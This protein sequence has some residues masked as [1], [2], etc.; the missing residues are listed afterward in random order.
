M[1]NP[2]ASLVTYKK[3][4]NPKAL[5]IVFG[6]RPSINRPGLIYLVSLNFIL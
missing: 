6:Y 5:L 2:Q 1:A 4:N 3:P